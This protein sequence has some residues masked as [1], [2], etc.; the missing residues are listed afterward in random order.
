MATYTQIIYHIIFSTKN[1]RPVLHAER[2][3]DLFRYTWGIIK[4]SKCHLFR[5]NGVEDHLH[6]LTSLHQ[7]ICLADLVKDIKTGSSK[8][9]KENGVFPEFD[10]WQDG[11][12]AFTHSIGEKS[13]LIEYIK[14]QQEHH[15]TVSFEDELKRMLDEMGVEYDPKYLC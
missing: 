10:H 6:I 12:A 11:Y 14:S 13:R 3:E 8:W 5:I 1:R 9:I 4:N 7:T 2:R 15:R